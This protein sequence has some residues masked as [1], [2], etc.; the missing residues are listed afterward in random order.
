M[1]LSLEQQPTTEM[2]PPLP[3]PSVSPAVDTVQQ[4]SLQFGVQP[5]LPPLDTL[6]SMPRLQTDS[7]TEDTEAGVL[8][9]RKE[10]Q[11]QKVILGK[12]RRSAP[13]K[14]AAAAAEA[15][16]SAEEP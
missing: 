15:T 14:S 2:P 4:E 7:A 12:R 5:S 6:P 13:A 3:P 9:G 1:S 10:R 11:I 8:A 16:E